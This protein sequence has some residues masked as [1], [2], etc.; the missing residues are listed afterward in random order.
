[1]EFKV[2][3]N[4]LFKKEKQSGII[5]KINSLYKVKIETPEGFEINVS[6]ND[7]ILIDSLTD[8]SSAYGADFYQKDLPR[9]KKP[10]PKQQRSQTILKVDLHI[11]LLSSDY[12]YMDNFEIVQFQLK[13]CQQKLEYALNSKITKVVIVHGIGT[14]V[15][16]KEV[17]KLLQNYKLRYYLSKDGGATEVML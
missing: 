13:A 15:L 7:I 16:K 1:M 4:V 11:E 3:D 8:R 12:Q 10:S 2:G 17:H 14:G 5:T 6:I 9:N